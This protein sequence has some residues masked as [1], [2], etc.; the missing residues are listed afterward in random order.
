MRRNRMSTRTR[1]QDEWLV[2]GGG[3]DVGHCRP[4]GIV[5]LLALRLRLRGKYRY[6][7]G[8]LDRDDGLSLSQVPAVRSLGP[9]RQTAGLHA[10]VDPPQARR[11]Y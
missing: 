4:L 6:L 1:A 2:S 3:A 10:A 7:L 8:R 11:H 5:L 9:R